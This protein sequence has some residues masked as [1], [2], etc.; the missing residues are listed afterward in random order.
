MVIQR[1][2]GTKK[3]TGFALLF[4]AA[5]T[6]AFLVQ[7]PAMEDYL[8]HLARIYVLTTA[9]TSDANPFYQVSWGLYPAVAMDLIVPQLARFIDVEPAGKF[10]FIS[11]QLLIV[12]G[13]IALEFSVKRR[14]QI[15]GFAALLTLYSLPFSLGLVNFEFGTGLAL[16]GVA[17]WIAL[18]REGKWRARFVVHIIFSSILFLAH[19]FA[20]GI[21]GLVIGVFELRRSLEL[22]FN[23]RQALRTVF[24]LA[25]PV[26]LMLLLML[27]TG[28]SLG[29][30][31]NQWWFSWKPIWLVL[32]PNGYSLT[33][34]SVSACVVAILAFYGVIKGSLVLSVD[35]KWIAFFFALVFIAMPFKLFGSRM[36]DIRMIAAAALI[37]PAFMN[38]APRSRS[39]GSFAAAVIVGLILVNTSYVAYV[40]VSYQ[41]DYEA[42]K[43][44]FALLRE[45]SFILVGSTRTDNTTLLMDAPMWRAPTLAV[46]YAKAF[47]SSLYTVPGTHAVEIKSEWQHLDIN[48]KTETYEPPSLGS[49][50]TIAEGGNVPSAPQYLRNWQNDFDFVYLLG[51]HTP[52]AFPNLLVEIA[53][54]RRFTLYRVRRE[55]SPEVHQ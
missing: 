33:L 37:L 6:P 27:G 17:S 25:S 32:F 19:F 34:A 29:E 53:T 51:P 30:N 13:A 36:A 52:D 23:T 21:Y 18:S 14:H 55:I 10:F 35:G 20:L 28:A 40:W 44:S 31:D 50:K 1:N 11:A 7:I 46:Y 15:S 8:D 16:W 9:G 47:V 45:N 5:I 26:G 3:A 43:A 48:N 54:G 2:A 22:R 41:K 4:A 38:F 24:I 39:F 12:T 49:L 42:M